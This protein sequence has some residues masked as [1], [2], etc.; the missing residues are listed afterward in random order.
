MTMETEKSQG[1]HLASRRP[2]RA[3]GI[4]LVQ[5]ASE[6]RRRLMSQLQDVQAGRE[7][8]LQWIG[9]HP[10]TSGKATCFT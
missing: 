2:R 8:D 1:L 9:G 10:P 3:K 4:V 5:I 7:R 6:G